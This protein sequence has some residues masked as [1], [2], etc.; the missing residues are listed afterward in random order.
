[1]ECVLSLVMWAPEDRHGITAAPLSI[2]WTAPLFS[3]R[4]ELPARVRLAVR[5]LLPPFS[6]ARYGGGPPSPP[7]QLKSRPPIISIIP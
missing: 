3:R 5:G 4:D 6:Q 1:M 7:V 2:L